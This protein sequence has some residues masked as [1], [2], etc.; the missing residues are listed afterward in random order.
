MTWL[1]AATRWRTWV[2]RD[3]P[4]RVAAYLDS[5][6]EDG[7]DSISKVIDIH[8]ATVQDIDKMYWEYERAFFISGSILTWP[9]EHVN[10]MRENIH[11]RLGRMY[12][13]TR[14]VLCSFGAANGSSMRAPTRNAIYLTWN[15][16]FKI[17]ESPTVLRHGFT[18]G[19]SGHPQVG[20]LHA[21]LVAL[22][23]ATNYSGGHV[24]LTNSTPP[25]PNSIAI[26]MEFL[27]SHFLTL[28]EM[29]Q[30]SQLGSWARDLL[31][32]PPR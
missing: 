7:C 29:P 12:S 8:T 31:G 2:D 19:W 11:D 30:R 6:E 4:G 1:D 13:V 16:Q 27:V 17:Y 23:Y 14:L 20:E 9:V 26:G 32:N 15:L 5:L 28:I 25:E 3:E 22:W 21:D 24:Y 10:A 18:R